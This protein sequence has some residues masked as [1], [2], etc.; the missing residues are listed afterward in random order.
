MGAEG[1][2]QDLSEGVTM[3]SFI[4]AAAVAVAML[5]PGFASADTE[6]SDLFDQEH[7]SLSKLPDRHLSSLL[8]PGAVRGRSRPDSFGY[9]QAWLDTQPKA[10]GGDQWRCLA[11]A[12]YF[13]ARGETVKGQFAVAE[14]ILNRVK[15]SQY[16]STP[17]DVIK[18]GTGKR[19]QCQFTYTC[20][21]H[22]E[23]IA[24]RRAFERVAKVARAALD[25]MANGL[26]GGATHYH[27]RF[28]KPN[29][30]NVYH[31][32]ARIGM[33]IFYRPNFRTASSD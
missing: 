32:T 28:V 3:K 15:S 7:A 14:V 1:S 27:T 13:E 30:A 22:E 5:W 4:G 21:G 29:W 26:T 11:E 17:C 18:Q 2:I 16:P 12:L 33:H 25:G 31:R 20:D 10:K 19:F 23:V 9:T 8:S 24:E 6:L